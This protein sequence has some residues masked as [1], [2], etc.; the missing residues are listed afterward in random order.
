MLQEVPGAYIGIGSG[1][2]SH[3]INLHNER[4]DF[5]DEILTLGASYWLSLVEALLPA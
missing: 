1:S 4:F 5:N 3:T 2:P